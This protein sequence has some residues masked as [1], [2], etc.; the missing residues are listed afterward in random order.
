MSIKAFWQHFSEENFEDAATAFAALEKQAQADTM[1]QLFYKARNAVTP[2]SVSILYRHLHEGAA[3][4]DFHEKWMP[5]SDQ[6]DP[7]KIGDDV[8]QHYFP[9]PLRV[10]NA[11]N[12]EN[13]KEIL[14]VGLH[15]MTDEQLE[16]YM[17]DKEAQAKGKVRGESIAQVADKISTAVF[18]VKSDDNLGA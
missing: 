6:C 13:P 14:S 1:K 8:Y 2:H 17:A 12:M 3:F 5:S 10:I 9:V 16:A 4:E 15:W 11:V 18:I 7:E